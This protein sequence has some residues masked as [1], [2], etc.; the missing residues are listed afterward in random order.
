MRLDLREI[1]VTYINL[2]SSADNRAY[3]EQHVLNRYDFQTWERFDADTINE[4]ADPRIL[5]DRSLY[6]VLGAMTHLEIIERHLEADSLPFMVLED[7]VAV[8]SEKFVYDLPDWCDAFWAGT[9][10]SHPNLSFAKAPSGN[11]RVYDMLGAH[12]I[13][14]LTRDFAEAYAELLRD[15]IKNE[16]PF[17]VKNYTVQNRFHVECPDIPVFY[18]RDSPESQHKY[19]ALTFNGVRDVAEGKFRLNTPYRKL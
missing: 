14:Y 10:V 18:Q 4:K 8:R 15:A 13:V 9:S 7:D 11:Y 3:I 17:D 2:R 5:A 16:Y 6:H 1:P 19:E 12:G